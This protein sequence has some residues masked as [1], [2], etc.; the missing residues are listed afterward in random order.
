VSP[1]LGSGNKTEIYNW[2]VINSKQVSYSLH[3]D[4]IE[5]S[6]NWLVCLKINSA[7]TKAFFSWNLALF[8]QSRNPNTP[9]IPNKVYR[10]MIKV[11]LNKHKIKF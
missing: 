11:S 7:I 10:P 8:L 2:S 4:W 6:E 9:G 5:I 3:K 1:R